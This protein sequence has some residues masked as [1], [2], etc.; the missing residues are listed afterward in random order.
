MLPWI[1]QLGYKVGAAS[2]VPT[3]PP[4]TVAPAHGSRKRKRYYVEI[5]GQNFPVANAQEA[6][7]LL[8]Q[9]R[10]IAERQAEE[11]GQRTQ[12]VL[13]RKKIVPQVEITPPAIKVSPEIRAEVVPIIDDIK[14]LYV[15]A[16]ELAELK[17]LLAK[18]KQDDDDE[19][20][21][22]LLL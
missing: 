12:K 9:A 16:A 7:E 21:L 5:D 6:S 4:A 14:R 3:P 13:R 8:K 10:A 15:K 11:K 2:V 18:A 22:W 17:L 1:V 19:E 20:D